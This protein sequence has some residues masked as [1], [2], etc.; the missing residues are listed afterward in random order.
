MG[1]GHLDADTVVVRG[2]LRRRCCAPPAPASTPS[3]ASTPAR[4]TWPSARCARPATTPPPHRP[5]GFCLVNNVAV[6]AMALA[7]R[8]E[9]VLIV[10]YDAHHGNGT[11]DVFYDDPRVLY[12]SF[13]EYPLY[14]GTG[15]LEEIGGGEGAGTTVNFPFPRGRH[16][17]RLPPGDRR[18]RCARSSRQWQ[19]TWLLISA[20][21]DA[22]RR[23]PL[24]GL[25]LTAGD[26][27]DLTRELPGLVPAGPLHRLPRG[28]LRP[29]GPAP[30]RT[31][32]RAGARW[33]ASTYRPEAAVERWPGPRRSSTRWPTSAPP[34]RTDAAADPT[35][36]RCRS[37]AP[38]ASTPVIP[39]RL[40]PVLERTSPAGR[41]LRRGR[42]PALP[43]GRG[44][45]RPA[46]RPGPVAG[47][48]HR[49]HHRRPPGRDQAAASRAGPTR[50]GPRASA[51]AP[52]AAEGRLGLRDHHPP[53]RGLRPRLPQARRRVRRRGRG[54]P[55]PPRLHRQRH[56]AAPCPSPG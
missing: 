42:P 5:M 52:S 48:R 2:L 9:R 13:H 40:R 50:C 29:R 43:R 21:F 49:P 47:P 17:R 28:R 6:T 41:A 32:R 55:V 4:A 45:P 3:A 44:R 24:T 1:G 51:S 11:Q 38:V 23:D 19:P 25:G 54:R 22:H 10:D 33:S 18:G 30:T 12:V 39:D 46:A 20:G 37:A 16:R 27:A 31:R 34:I 36:P 53:G 26:Y 15:A 7:D 56:G 8:G 35:G 14:P